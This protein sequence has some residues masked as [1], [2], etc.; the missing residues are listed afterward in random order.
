MTSWNVIPDTDIDAE[1]PLTESL[2][3]RLRDNL[4]ATAE[5]DASVPAG[6]LVTL[7]NQRT[8]ET[9]TTFVL[10]PD[11]A[12]GVA[13][14]ALGT[15]SVVQ[16]SIKMASTVHSAQTGTSIATLI[17]LTGAKFVMGLEAKRRN[18]VGAG[19]VISH[20]GPTPINTTSYLSQWTIS[21]QGV[22]F[23]STV[24]IDLRENYVSA[25]PPYDLGN[26]QIPLFQFLRFGAD[27]VIKA[28][29][30][31]Q[32]PPWAYNGPT[33]SL[34]QM[35]R[36]GKDIKRVRKR[37]VREFGLDKVDSREVTMEEYLA[38]NT[39][40]MFDVIADDDWSFKN[41]DMN[42]V[43]HPFNNLDEGDYVVLLDPIRTEKL[44]DEH[45]IGTV[46]ADLIQRGYIEVDNVEL[47]A[48]TPNGVKAHG[49]KWKDTK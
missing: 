10:Q 22:G 19:G 3:F 21:V 32:D 48:I 20:Y 45:N 2:F 42:L 31:M 1:S 12:N 43:P 8:D 11:G 28:A 38:Q 23:G 24:A 7:D 18:V 15:D 33:S 6:E 9:D 29:S 47:D 39:S 49:F 36:I 27:G 46:I 41:A 35:R 26:G 44:L 4:I 5:G 37:V 34:V 17:T 25:S 16:G 30:Q 14:A 13:W 40:I